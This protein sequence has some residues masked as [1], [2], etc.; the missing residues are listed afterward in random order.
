MRQ[1]PPA[2]AAIIIPARTISRAC[3]T[4][5]DGHER[6]PLAHTQ[7]RLIYQVDC[8]PCRSQSAKALPRLLSERVGQANRDSQLIRVTHVRYDRTALVVAKQPSVEHPGAEA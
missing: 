1:L 5:P 2:Q 6:P 7:R 4:S 3:A 8:H